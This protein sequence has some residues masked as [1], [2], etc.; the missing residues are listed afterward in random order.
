MTYDYKPHETLNGVF[1]GVDAFATNDN[2]RN[3]GLNTA[4]IV[5]HVWFKGQYFPPSSILQNPGK[6]YLG[7]HIFESQ[8][9]GKCLQVLNCPRYVIVEKNFDVSYRVK[10]LI[11]DRT[12][13]FRIGNDADFVNAAMSSGSFTYDSPNHAVL[14]KLAEGGGLTDIHLTL[15]AKT[16]GNH[17]SHL[18]SWNK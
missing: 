18:Y 16:I 13:V 6:L 7:N 11:S 3:V 1:W 5:T 12:I 15:K 8:Y 2:G 14:C 9:F 4:G 17:Y 10:N